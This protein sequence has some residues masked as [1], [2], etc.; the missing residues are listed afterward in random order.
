MKKILIAI[1]LA[2]SLPLFSAC[3]VSNTE[4]ANSLEGNMTRL[5]YSI[6]YLDSVSTEELTGL[7]NNSSYFTHSSLYTGD[8]VANEETDNASEL[9]NTEPANEVEN[10]LSGGLI[11]NSTVNS[12]GRTAFQDALYRTSTYTSGLDNVNTTGGYSAGTVDMTLLET[13]ADDLNQILLDISGKR[14][15]I[16][17]YC[18]DLRSGRATLSIEDKNAISEYNDIIKETTNFLNNNTGALTNY[19]NGISSISGN[20]NSAELINAK[21]IRANE[22]LKTRYAKLDTCLDSL[23]AII[24]ILVNSIGY[25]YTELYNASLLNNLPDTNNITNSALDSSTGDNETTNNPLGN[26]VDPEFSLDESNLTIGD[27][28]AND[29]MTVENATTYPACPCPN[30]NNN[31]TTNSN[32]NDNILNNERTTGDTI[33]NYNYDGGNTSN[34]NSTPTNNT[35]GVANNLNNSNSEP[36]SNAVNDAERALAGGLTKNQN[37]EIIPRENVDSVVAKV[38]RVMPTTLERI[39][40]KPEPIEEIKLG[41]AIEKKEKAINNQDVTSPPVL[42]FSEPEI[43]ESEREL[44]PE[45]LP[46][47]GDKKDGLELTPLP[48]APELGNITFLPFVYEE[49]DV[50]R[51]V[52]R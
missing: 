40:K 8:P 11:T 32:T 27:G 2:C 25:D 29:N 47:A 42:D 41:T 44:T 17:L 16:M 5:V 10:A 1:I 46:F 9:T 35:N 38:S 43:V 22:V 18:T 4:L 26:E 28:T 7:V 31:G 39:D 14:G 45:L 49:S 20:E 19:F 6:G 37:S 12:S 33:I 23:N 3:E 30:T 21:L 15:V 51:K 36:V 48:V 52:P 34:I 24:N 50:T 13:N